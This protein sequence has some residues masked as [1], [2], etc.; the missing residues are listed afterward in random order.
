MW[1]P[2][3]QRLCLF[4]W[5]VDLVNF[6]WKLWIFTIDIIFSTSITPNLSRSS[7]YEGNNLLELSIDTSESEEDNW[8]DNEIEYD[9]KVKVSISK[10]FNEFL[11]LRVPKYCVMQC[12]H[13]IAFVEKFGSPSQKKS[14]ICVCIIKN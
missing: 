8:E 6:F 3:S 14:F 7:S 13:I 9:N 10:Y 1:Y 5:Q 4:I 2:F 11:F 12:V